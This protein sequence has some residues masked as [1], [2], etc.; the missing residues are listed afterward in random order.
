M[1][2][3]SRSEV[4]G[5]SQC[6]PSPRS[7]RTTLRCMA[8]LQGFVHATF[9]TSPDV[10]RGRAPAASPAP[11]ALSK[12]ATSEDVSGFLRMFFL[13]GA[14]G[15]HNLF[16]TPGTICP[17]TWHVCTGIKPRWSRNRHQDWTMRAHHSPV[18]ETP[19]FLL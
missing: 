8:S 13:P 12:S 11:Q 9:P 3:K 10:A 5:L 1:K 4:R 18:V 19:D 16:N 2:K 17:P 7:D 15:T 14:S 6:I